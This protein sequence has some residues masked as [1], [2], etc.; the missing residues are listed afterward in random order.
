M[1][2]STKPPSAAACRYSARRA[3]WHEKPTNRAL[4]DRLI[5]SIVSFSS[6][7]LGQFRESAP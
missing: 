2:A 1:I 5:A 3:S 6:R 7:P 4:P